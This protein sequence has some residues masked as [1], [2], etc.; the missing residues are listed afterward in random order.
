MATFRFQSF[1]PQKAAFDATDL[2]TCRIVVPFAHKLV[3][4]SLYVQK[5]VLVGTVTAALNQTDVGDARAGS[6][7]AI[8]SGSDLSAVTDVHTKLDFTLI[9]AALGVAPAD[10]TYFLVLAATN[11][12]DRVDEP[13]LSIEVTDDLT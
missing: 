8:L 12:A 11:T 13:V 3:K 10:R 9:S 4:A 2:Y 5:V 6:Q 1:D 7:W